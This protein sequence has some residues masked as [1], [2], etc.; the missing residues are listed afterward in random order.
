MNK[1]KKEDTVMV[2][3]GSY[4]GETGR[5]IKVLTSKNR[6][7]VEGVN[8]AKKHIRPT[9]DNPQGGIVEKELSIHLSNL[10]LMNKGKLVKVGFGVDKNRKRFRINKKN[11]N[12]ID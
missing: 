2:I 3:S 6:A 5:V 12:K 10:G 11:G 7:I 4:K 9:Q 8:K 1:I